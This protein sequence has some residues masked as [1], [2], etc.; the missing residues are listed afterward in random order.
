MNIFL[1][2]GL[3]FISSNTFYSITYTLEK[4]PIAQSCCDCDEEQKPEIKSDALKQA[5]ETQSA[6]AAAS[7]IER[8]SESDDIKEALEDITGI[9]H[10]A[11]DNQDKIKKGY[12]TYKCGDSEFRL[13]GKFKPEA[14]YGKNTNMINDANDTDHIF[15]IR[16]T[17]DL[18]FEYHYGLL[19]RNY[20]VVLFKTTLRNK[21]VWGN[22]DSIAS[23]SETE[24]KML[25]STLGAHKH[26]LPRLFYWMRE[27]WLQ[28]A[29]ND[30]MGLT[31]NNHHTFT[32]GAFSFQ[33][34]RGITLGD[35]FAVDPDSLGYY[36]PNAVDQY[37]F[38]LKLS[39]DL[40]PNCLGYDLYGAILD[41]KMDSFEATNLRIKEQ[42]Y[43]RKFL[44]Q[45]RHW[46][47]ALCCCR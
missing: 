34:G 32:L 2:L 38:G 22:A 28:V 14:F 16:H 7:K 21:A 43:G 17:I 36:S 40:H 31:F 11:D 26:G 30:L 45:K 8:A 9:G 3:F 44:Q 6:S 10:K 23:T 15:F 29:L 41:N 13:N 46:K 4:E 37:A 18:N 1:L 35:A 33:L 12:L 20:D 24:I 27:L 25:D 42:Q 47:S 19:S 39:G 5:L